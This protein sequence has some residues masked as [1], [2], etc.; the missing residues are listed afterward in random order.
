MLSLWIGE[1]EPRRETGAEKVARVAARHR[2]TVKR[3]MSRTTDR[4]VIRARQEAFWTLREEMG[5]SS[6]RIGQ[7][8]HMDH[9]TVLWGIQQHLRRIGAAD[10]LT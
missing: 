9:T 5:W 6:P 8:F 7:F 1:T 4:E 10:R 3:V 2:V